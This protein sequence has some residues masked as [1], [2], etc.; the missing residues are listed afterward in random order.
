[1][2]QVKNV[3]ILCLFPFFMSKIK[4]KRKKTKILL[5]LKIVT[6]LILEIRTIMHDKG[7]ICL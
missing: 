2:K 1:M 6:D 4:T 5:T 7:K 3:E